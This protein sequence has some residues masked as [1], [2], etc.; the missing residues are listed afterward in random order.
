MDSIPA[1]YTLVQLTSADSDKQSNWQG[2]YESFTCS[3]LGS[4]CLIGAQ[5]EG[6]LVVGSGTVKPWIEIKE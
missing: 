6:M 4:H 5:L 3:L 2:P 1:Q